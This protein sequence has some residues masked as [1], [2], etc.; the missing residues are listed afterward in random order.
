MSVIVRDLIQPKRIEAVQTSQYEAVDVKA[1]I[2]KSTVTNTT[3]NN[4]SFN[5]NIFYPTESV[6]DSNL[7]IDN[8]TVGPG[9]TYLCTELIGH[10]IEDGGILSAI[11]SSANSLTIKVSGREISS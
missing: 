3:A 8:I 5:I 9:E 11:A 7:I 4:A 1:I 10:V 2:D 6:Q